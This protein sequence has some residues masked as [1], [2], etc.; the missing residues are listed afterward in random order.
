MIPELS[1]FALIRAFVT[2]E[3]AAKHDENYMPEAK[4]AIDKA[5]ATART[6]KQ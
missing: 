3:V 4:D 5:H 6:L 1:H 2:V